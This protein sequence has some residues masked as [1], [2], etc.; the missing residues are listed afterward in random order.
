MYGIPQFKQIKEVMYQ[1]EIFTNQNT[2]CF[3]I[4]SIL[5]SKVCL[6]DLEHF[7]RLLKD[8]EKENF[9]HEYI[10]VQIKQETQI[11]HAQEASDLFEGVTKL[12][13][14]K[15]MLLKLI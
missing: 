15:D 8:S 1:E 5:L 2:L 12:Q 11:A 9:A 10:L 4:E 7:K 6:T 14:K 3:D 13:E